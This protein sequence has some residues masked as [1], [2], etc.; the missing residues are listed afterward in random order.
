MPVWKLSLKVAT[1]GPSRDFEGLRFHGNFGQGRDFASKSR[2]WEV[3]AQLIGSCTLLSRWKLGRLQLVKVWSSSACEGLVESA[4]ACRDE[5][6]VEMKASRVE[7]CIDFSALC[8]DESSV[9]FD[10]SRWGC[11]RLQLLELKACRV[12]NSFEFDL[13]R[14]KIVCRLECCA[15]NWACWLEGYFEFSSIVSSPCRLWRLFDLRT[16]QTRVQLA[17]CLSRFHLH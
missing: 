17:T 7:G 13:S 1:L 6:V 11:G 3:S 15:S 4:P 12:V 16:R 10:L 2:L 5:G 8:R 14:W 9:D